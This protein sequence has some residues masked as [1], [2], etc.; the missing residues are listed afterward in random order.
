MALTSRNFQTITRLTLLANIGVVIIF[1]N[2]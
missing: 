2:E 1:T